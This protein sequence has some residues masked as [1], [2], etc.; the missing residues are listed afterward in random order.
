[1]TLRIKWTDEMLSE[2]G[3]MPDSK[4]AKKYRISKQS[5][6]NK[7]KELGI[8]SHRKVS[9]KWNPL[10]NWT[11][12]LDALVGTMPDVKLAEQLGVS[13][14][15]VFMRRVNLGIPKFSVWTDTAISLLGT[16]TDKDLA[17][18]LGVHETTVRCK[19]LQHG[20]SSY[21]SMFSI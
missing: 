8:P 19:R 1:M 7:R 18:L 13:H 15:V 4:L 10:I 11:P 20:I 21:R 12:E 14:H 2:L 16:M 9:N 6:S 17:E 5:I 3:T